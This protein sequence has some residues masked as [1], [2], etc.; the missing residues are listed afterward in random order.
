M[1]REIVKNNYIEYMLDDRNSVVNHARRLGFTV[2]QVAPGTLEYQI[3][4]HPL[5]GVLKLILDGNP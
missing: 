2:F 4:V 5:W 1:W 3:K